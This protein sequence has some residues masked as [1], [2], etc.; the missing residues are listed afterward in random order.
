MPSEPA[1]P[2]TEPSPPTPRRRFLDGLLGFGFLSSVGA[3]V[4]PV[5]RFLIPPAVA[6]PPTDSIT[7]GRLSD[8]A[9]GTGR[10]F[11]F[12]ARPALV[13]RTPAGDLRAFSA[14]CTHLD[15]TVQYRQDLEAIW[16]ACHDGVFDLGGAVVSGPPPRP[17]D[18]L[19]VNLRGDPG[20]EE[21]VV[22][23]V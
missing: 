1:L 8:M 21:I 13:V 10:V 12:G 2:V 19:A 17:L 14:I 7:V 5:F 18:R 22:S 4:Y 9:P 16:C 20:Q 3:V 23:R 6:E 11:K 15:C